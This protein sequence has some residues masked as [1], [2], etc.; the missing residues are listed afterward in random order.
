MQQ[1]SHQNAKIFTERTDRLAEA[2]DVPVRNL[3]PWLGISGTTLFQCRREDAA[4]S[5]KTWLKLE[6]AEERARRPPP[7]PF[8]L[9]KDSPENPPPSAAAEPTRDEI[10]SFVASVLDRAGRHPGGLGWCYNELQDIF[11]PEKF[12]STSNPR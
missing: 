9:I 2:L 6:R 5:K 11:P 8:G 12:S 4:I 7:L 10:L 1:K 3:G